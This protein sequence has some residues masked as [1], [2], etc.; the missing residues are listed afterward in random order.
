MSAF[1]QSQ[2]LGEPFRKG[3]AFTPASEPSFA[4]E[5]GYFTSRLASTAHG[6]GGV[7]MARVLNHIVRV[8][9]L[10]A[11]VAGGWQAADAQ[12][13]RGGGRTAT[14]AR[15]GGGGAHRGAGASRGGGSRQSATTSRSSSR[16]HASASRG[17]HRSTHHATAN[18]GGSRSAKANRTANA[19][20][21]RTASRNGNVN[22]NTYV[23]RNVAASRNWNGNY[24]GGARVHAGYY[25]WPRGYGYVRRSIGWVMPRP[26]LA[27][28]YYYTGWATL[29]LV[30]PS[31]GYQ[32]IRYG[33]DLLLVDIATGDVIDVRYGVF[34]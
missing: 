22:R 14:H 5:S 32:W 3:L 31:A 20:R 19:G 12:G 13:G 16:Q 10:L 11:L 4:G 1:E 2:T 33:P 29:G 7:K 24:W 21:N 17:G 9:A 25:S 23:N 34:G 18:R 15:S 26:F 6:G 27:A 30:A 8:I 28:A